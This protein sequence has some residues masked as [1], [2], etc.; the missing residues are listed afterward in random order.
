V[1]LFYSTYNK[2][3]DRLLRPL[4]SRRQRR[5]MIPGNLTWLD[6]EDFEEA[7]KKHGSVVGIPDQRV[8]FLQAALRGLE[9]VEGDIVEC[10]VRHGRS[11]LFMASANKGRRE[12]HIFDSF[13]GLSDPSEKDGETEVFKKDGKTR[14]FKIRNIDRVLKRFE[15]YPSIKVYQGWI[16]E[17]FSE[18]AERKFAMVHVDVDLYE[19]TLDALKFFWDRLNLGGMIICDDYGASGYPGAKLA[20]DEFFDDKSETPI[21]L[22]SGQAFVTKVF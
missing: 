11:T 20:M 1:G 14:K 15:S 22:P 7:F 19:P 6:R 5:R 10:G 18:I 9:H 3:H 4:M 17:R 8:F 12:I 16:P 2:W 21:E 13:E